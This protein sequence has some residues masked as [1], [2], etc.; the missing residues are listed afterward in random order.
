[1]KSI[2]WILLLAM[3]PSME[4]AHQRIRD[5]AMLQ[6]HVSLRNSFQKTLLRLL[7][8][9]EKGDWE[10]LYGM[11]WPK[12]IENESKDTFINAHLHRELM[13]GR[14]TVVRVDNAIDNAA[15]EKSGMWTALGCARF[16]KMGRSRPIQSAT[17]IYWM[18][19]GTRKT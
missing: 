16:I 11:Q 6:V 12:I 19:T 18:G 5:H 7:S 13:K 9:Q 3:A 8:P 10:A 2:L 1:M 17:T 14:F 4:S 15:T